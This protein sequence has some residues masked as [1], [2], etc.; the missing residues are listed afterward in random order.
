[1]ALFLPLKVALPLK[2]GVLKRVFMDGLDLVMQLQRKLRARLVL[3]L[4]RILCL[5]RWL[6]TPAGHMA[7]QLRL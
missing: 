1:M 2:C 4:A 7:I 5:D 6:H 3:G